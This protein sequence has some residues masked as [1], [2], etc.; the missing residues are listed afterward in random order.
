MNDSADRPAVFNH[1]CLQPP[2]RENT[3]CPSRMWARARSQVAAM[4][5]LS[6]ALGQHPVDG[7][8]QHWQRSC[9]VALVRQREGTWLLPRSS[10]AEERSVLAAELASSDSALVSLGAHTQ[11]ICSDVGPPSSL[12]L[13]VVVTWGSMLLKALPPFQV[14]GLALFSL[15]ENCL[16]ARMK[17]GGI[18]QRT[19]EI[20]SAVGTPNDAGS[21][22]AASIRLCSQI[23]SAL[24]TSTPW[25]NE[26][27]DEGESCDIR[28]TPLLLQLKDSSNLRSRFFA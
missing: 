20:A 1:R 23:N 3:W 21:G 15:R 13:L 10:V 4:R 17:L 6:D 27:R 24:A 16:R 11:S 2:F 19:L 26:I 5:N 9:N 12:S 22:R 7:S 14:L 25:R 8:E 28:S 18:L